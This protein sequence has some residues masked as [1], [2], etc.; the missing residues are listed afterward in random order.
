[1]KTPA[2]TI[3]NE[4]L[5]SVGLS[6]Q[7][8]SEREFPGEHW[9]I[10]TIDA[11]ALVTAQS[12]AGQI[13]SELSDALTATDTSVTA[14]FRPGRQEPEN[15]TNA[16]NTGRLSSANV[17]QLIQL[18][19]ARSRTSEAI[20][21]LAY[22]EDPRASLTA[23]AASRHHLVY[24]RRGVGKTA[25]LLEVKR[26]S[27]QR[28]A[29][30]VWMNSHTLRNQTPEETF[31]TVI[32]AVLKSLLH[33]IGASKSPTKKQIL[34]LSNRLNATS[35]DSPVAADLIPEI[36]S[37]LRSILRAEVLQLFVYLDDFYL[38]PQSWQPQIL[39]YLASSLRDCDGWLKVASIERL[40]RPF[41][42]S[43]RIGIEVP[44]DAS[45]IDLDVTLENPA[46]TQEFLESVMNTYIDKAGLGSVGSIAKTEALGRLVLASGG[47]PRDYL[48][49]FSNS[50]VVARERRAQAAEIGREDVSGAAGRYS[51]SKKRDLEQDVNS[52]E[53]QI[54]ITALETLISGVKGEGSTFFRVDF[55]EK[56]TQGYELL[57]RLVDMRFAHLV[58]SALSDQKQAGVK[59]EAYILALS[60]YS[61]VRLQR[62]LNTLDIERGE[63]VLRLTGK[64]GS[65]KKQSTQQLRYTLRKSPLLSVKELI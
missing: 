7:E 2:K 3:V 37:T 24:G 22:R 14:F 10:V 39:D 65:S 13:E 8:V 26:L 61:D 25:L 30:T 12:L 50:I 49:L 6:A 42:V 34:D 58:Q 46:Q 64:A 59:Y 19:E 63:W 48:N 62:G 35:Q 33:R 32:S 11:A 60:E 27:E 1:M 20:P 17:D 56:S 15:P 23:V 4:I 51:Q 31:S 41:D 40:T 36:N 28:G 9:V 38:I 54:I 16:S 55:R 53:S 57:A 47:V 52:N 45:T 18:L 5:Q 29:A 44:H 21:S 43:E